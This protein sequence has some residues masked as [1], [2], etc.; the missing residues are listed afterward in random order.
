M[1]GGS[2]EEEK[3]LAVRELLFKV[4]E[5]FQKYIAVVVTDTANV[6]YCILNCTLKIVTIIT[7]LQL[8]SIINFL[9]YTFYHDKKV[10]KR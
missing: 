7:K 8:I 6:F 1:V 4:I 5:K 10:F 2:G 9:L 3:S